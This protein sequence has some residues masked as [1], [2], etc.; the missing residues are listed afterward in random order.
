MLIDCFVSF[1]GHMFFDCGAL[2]IGLAASFVSRWG[3]DD[4]FSYGYG[5]FE[6][7][8]AFV[9]AILLVFIAV[10]VLLESLERFLEPP[11]VCTHLTV[12]L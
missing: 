1:T 8:S 12:Y 9:N 11:Q 2:A 6:V 7:L 4:S 5:R 10:S 3:A